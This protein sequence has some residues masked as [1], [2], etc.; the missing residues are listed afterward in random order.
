[1][2]AIKAY[3]KMKLKSVNYTGSD[4]FV[5]RHSSEDLIQTE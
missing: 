2:N 5:L 4:R 1:M 3:I